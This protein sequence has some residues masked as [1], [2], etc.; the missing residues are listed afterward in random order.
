MIS[1]FGVSCNVPL[2]LWW[3]S[4]LLARFLLFKACVSSRGTG[5]EDEKG[6]RKLVQGRAWL[7]VALLFSGWGALRIRFF[8]F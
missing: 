1:F 3:L 5:G 7:S 4:V 8:F 6:K 2:S